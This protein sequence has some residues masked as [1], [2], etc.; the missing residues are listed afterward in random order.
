M[1]PE[2]L[3]RII[4]GA[5]LSQAEAETAMA[6]IMDGQATPVQIAGLLVALKQRGETADEVAGFVKAMRERSVKVA[7]ADE[8][9]VDNCG[10]G[11]D[12]SHSF[13]ISTAAALVA[14]AAGVTVAKHGNRSVS[15]SCG[16]ADLLEAAG[17]RIDPPPERI[18]DHINRLG[19]GFMFA[20]QFHPAMKHAVQPRRELKM[21]TVFNLLGPMS[22][23]AGVRRQL[24]GVFAPQ[25][26]TLMAAV[27]QMTG[28]EHV[29]VVH[30]QDGL[31][32]I[33]VC[34]P[35]DYVELKDGVVTRGT[36][37]AACLGLD[38]YRAESLAGG[39]AA[40]NLT[41]LND[42][43]SGRRSVYLEAV[44]VNA[45]AL[46]YVAGRTS[47]LAEGIVEARAA[48]ESG[49]ARKKL[50]DWVAASNEE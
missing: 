40:Q 17:G 29:L 14:A 39:D 33:S 21:R 8:K 4:E 15:S 22:N 23:P 42:L 28:S 43:L 18:T 2:L 35:T 27:L 19:F 32:E 25:V 7:V 47:S 26:M 45:G 50:S 31:D 1:I 49:A 12:G 11:G 9:A 34:A 30:S 41:I 6:H 5:R 20:P 48:V 16:S 38:D 13:N 44:E 24:V 36:W 3:N 37:D 46:I 10:T